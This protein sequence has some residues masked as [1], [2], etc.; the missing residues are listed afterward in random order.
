MMPDRSSGGRATPSRKETNFA[1]L[2]ATR[3]PGTRIPTKFNGSAA[4]NSDELAGGL[5]LAH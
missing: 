2:E 5:L 4:R 3:S 1:E